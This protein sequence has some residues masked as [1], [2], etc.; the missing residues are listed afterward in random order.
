MVDGGYFVKKLT[1]PDVPD[2]DD[3]IRRY[4]EIL[5][6]MSASV[7]KFANLDILQAQ[8]LDYIDY[9]I[10]RRDAFVSAYSRSKEGLEAL[11]QAWMRSQIKADRAE[12]RKE[13]DAHDAS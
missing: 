4:Y 10:L 7:A 2:E 3:G 6:G 11:E 13:I 12:L 8:D 1:L 9:L 5:T